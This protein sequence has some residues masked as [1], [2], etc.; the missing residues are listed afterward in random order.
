[1][2]TATAAGKFDAILEQIQTLQARK[3]SLLAKI[4]QTHADERVA[5]ESA[6]FDDPTKRSDAGGATS[7]IG[8]I[9]RARH[10]AEESIPGIE[11]EIAA[12]GQVFHRLKAEI[13]QAQ[14]AQ[15]SAEVAKL[16]EQEAA[17]VA[18]LTDWL[19]Q[20][21]H[22]WADLC[23]FYAER[24]E[25]VF[26]DGAHVGDA[27]VQVPMQNARGPWVEPQPVDFLGMVEI[28]YTACADPRRVGVR[29]GAPFAFRGVASQNWL[30]AT[31]DLSDLDVVAPIPPNAR[32]RYA[33]DVNAGAH[34]GAGKQ[35][36]PEYRDGSG[37][38]SPVEW[39]R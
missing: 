27:S 33:S 18:R 13:E 5:R 30:E 15:L 35:V 12:A 9:L 14:L 7:P 2:A 28:I 6:I 37:R 10:E 16:N 4:D 22:A 23:R 19:E 26:L 1:M 20:G 36:M 24:Q 39:V 29:D 31:R 11:A 34:D 38:Q 3:A 25:H 17:H 8:K 21:L 32:P